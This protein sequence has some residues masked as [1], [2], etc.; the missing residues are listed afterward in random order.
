MIAHN[1]YRRALALLSSAVLEI[2]E[3]PDNLGFILVVH[4][5]GNIH[6]EN[7]GF[8]NY[9]GADSVA[10]FLQEMVPIQYG[11]VDSG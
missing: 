9:D 10:N 8:K 3:N 5:D 11:G 6:M 2:N 4:E 1:E 7:D